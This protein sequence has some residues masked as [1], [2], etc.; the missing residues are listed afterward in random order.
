MS[1]PLQG[2][3]VF[4]E[5]VEA[6]GFSAAATKLNLSRSAV[7]KTVARLEERL[8]VRL[9]HRTTRSQGLTQDGQVFYERCLRALGELR[10]GE[11]L[12]ESGKQEVA[13]RLRVSMPVLYGRRC[14]APILRDLAR[15]HPKLE[16]DLSFNDR[17]VDLLED[18]FDLVLR[19]VG[20]RGLDAGDG[21]TARRVGFQRMTVC[22]SPAYLRKHGTPRTLEALSGHDTIRYVRSGTARPW[23]FP[24]EDGTN[25]ELLPRSRLRFDD[26]E[27][28]MDAA[29][30][31]MGLAWLPCW[32]IQDAVRDKKLV[33]VLTDLPGLCFDIHALWPTSP[34]LPVRV[35]VAI[36]ALA[37][38]LPGSVK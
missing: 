10:A 38:K 17:L 22:A 18:G 36:D 25:V 21:L 16:L 31:G 19:S 34:H 23:L 35:R 33:R 27:A 3:A 30:A 24:Q 32:L 15:A 6:G 4:V 37:A 20:T 28:I 29:V 14:V 8:G 5:A 1:D 12:L 26:L 7:G 2:V 13:G 11:A 9:F